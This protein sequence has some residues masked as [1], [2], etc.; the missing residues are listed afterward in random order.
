M[1]DNPGADEIVGPSGLTDAEKLAALETYLKVLE[2]V[3]KSLRARLAVD[4]GRAHVE[5][6]GAFLPDGVKL[7]SV[8]RS[9]GRKSAKVVDEAAALVW[10]EK[11]YPDEVQTVRAIRPAFL[12]KLLDVAGS[13]PVGSD[14]LDSA[15]GQVLPFIKVVQ[16]N[17]YLVV[18]TTDEGVERMTALANGFTAMLEAGQ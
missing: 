11:N 10:A 16:G 14:G 18:T 15:T 8:G 3:A 9:D 6:V 5:K 4:M 17:P 13:L 7:A 12:K 1:T 2:P